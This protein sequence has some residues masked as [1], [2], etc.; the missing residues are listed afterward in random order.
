MRARC[1]RKLSS[2]AAFEGQNPSYSSTVRTLRRVAENLAHA[3]VRLSDRGGAASQLV[4]S[5][6]DICRTAGYRRSSRRPELNHRRRR[7]RATAAASS[8]FG[9]RR[10]RRPLLVVGI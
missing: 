7:D 3:T 8:L 1:Y 9:L 2:D 6:T 10:R 5:S 4:Y